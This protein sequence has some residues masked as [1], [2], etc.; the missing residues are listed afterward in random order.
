MPY[1]FCVVPLSIVGAYNIVCLF[2]FL[3]LCRATLGVNEQHQPRDLGMFCA[4]LQYSSVPLLGFVFVPCTFGHES[5]REHESAPNSR[6]HRGGGRQWVCEHPKDTPRAMLGFVG[7]WWWWVR[8]VEL[9]T[10]CALGPLRPILFNQCPG[11]KGYHTSLLGSPYI[12]YLHKQEFQGR[13]EG[14]LVCYMPIFDPQ[15]RGRGGG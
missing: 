15:R 11:S 10:A 3:S 5:A 6:I 14:Q 8:V 7:W 9:V 1:H 4:T 2:W 13:F 12:G